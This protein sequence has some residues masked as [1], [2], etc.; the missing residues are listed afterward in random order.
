MSE[1]SL[2]SAGLPARVVDVLKSTPIGYLSVASKKGELY[3]Y[4]VAF[5]YSDYKVYFLTPIGSAKMKFLRANPNVSFVIDNRKITST[6]D[7]KAACGAMVQGKARIFSFARMI[8]SMV[9]MGPM[10]QLPKKYPGM[11]SFYLKGKGLPDERKFYKYRLIRIDT[12]K[13]VYWIGYDFGKYAP[14]RTGRKSTPF[15]DAKG[16]PSK[17][18]GI[19][20]LAAESTDEEIEIDQIPASEDWLAELKSAISKGILSEDEMRLTGM[21]SLFGVGENV[22]PGELSAG[23]KD[24]LKKWKASK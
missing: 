13:I 23:E 6:S 24:I 5:H 21:S 1:G 7:I 3:S 10:G 2:S 15:E 14:P 17:L 20:K 11:F 18:E 8:A 19:T 22:K 12:T 9:S 16:D 4:P